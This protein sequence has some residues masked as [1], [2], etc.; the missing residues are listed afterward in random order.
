MH[1]TLDAATI[2]TTLP[3]LP[4]WQGDE[5]G[6]TRCYVFADF[7]SA[8][9]FMAAC[10][11]GIEALD[12][13]PTWTNTYNRVEVTLTS[14]DVGNRVTWRDV[15]LAHHLEAVLRAEGARWGPGGI[16]VP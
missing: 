7:P 4:G 13:H 15:R 12:H 11:P 1:G 10:I 5:H 2:A 3:S 8:M 9:A 14:H 6:L 16:E